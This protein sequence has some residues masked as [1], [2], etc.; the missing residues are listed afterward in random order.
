MDKSKDGVF[1]ICRYE[2]VVRI[3]P[4]STLPTSLK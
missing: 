1:Q 2:L 3:P 4:F